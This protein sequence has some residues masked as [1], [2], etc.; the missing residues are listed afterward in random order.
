MP[1]FLTE[2]APRACSRRRSIAM[3]TSCR[4][5]RCWLYSRKIE[6]QVAS[7]ASNKAIA[8][9]LGIS[10]HTAKFHVA[11]LLDKLD[12]VGHT[13]AVADAGRRRVINP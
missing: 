8:R 6:A 12:A 2:A 1:C 5:G 7:G 11:F 9:R 3:A 13:D 10:A 4:L